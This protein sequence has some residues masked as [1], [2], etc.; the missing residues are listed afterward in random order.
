MS[1]RNRFFI[2]LG[3]ILVIAAL[4]EARAANTAR[5][6]WSSWA[7]GAPN[8]ARKPLLVTCWMVPS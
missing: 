3:I 2:L 1:A 4:T 7:T 8:K 6:A 5:R